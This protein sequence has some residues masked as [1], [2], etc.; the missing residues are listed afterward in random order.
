MSRRLLIVDDDPTIRFAIRA[1]FE[2]R[3]LEI[4]E[5]G[6]C[7][8][9]RQTLESEE[10]DAVVLDYRLPDGTALDLM[11]EWQASDWPMPPVLLLTGHGSINLAVQAIKKGADNFVTKPV[12]L[13]TLA[14]MA[15]RA[16]E[17][18]SNRRAQL[19]RQRRENRR[20]IN[21]FV[22]DSP[23]IRR[24]ESEV[25]KVAKSSLPRK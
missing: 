23:A 5:A 22:G 24:L 10:P 12:D 8:T 11:D 17:N 14:L 1:F 16:L 18:Q 7:R 13:P 2:P 4:C 3:G 19:L 6:D 9:A 20:E 21:P 25:R 15:D